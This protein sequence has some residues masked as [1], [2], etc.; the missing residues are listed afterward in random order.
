ML[1]LNY[2]YKEV[3]YPFYCHTAKFT[4]W[5]FLCQSFR[6]VPL[7]GNIFALSLIVPLIMSIN[8]WEFHIFYIKTSQGYNKLIF[9]PKF[10]LV[11]NI[12]RQTMEKKMIFMRVGKRMKKKIIMLSILFYLSIANNACRYFPKFLKFS[13]NYWNNQKM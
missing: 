9:F 5:C 11:I 7:K 12:H 2:L 3:K 13:S 6:I 10:H 1:T 8:L 4:F